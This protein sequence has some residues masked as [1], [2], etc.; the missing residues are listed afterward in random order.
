MRF[1]PC[2][3]IHNGRV[4]QIV[5]GTLNEKCAVENFVSDKDAS[6]YAEIYKENKLY[7]GHIIML[8]PGNETQALMALK[9]F[10]GGMQ[11]GGGINPTNAFKFLDAGASHVIVT[12]YIFKDGIF[13]IDNLKSIKEKVGRDKLV[14]DLSCR[15]KNNSY[16][17]V[18]E[19]WQNFTEFTISKENIK[20]LEDYCSE[21]LVHAVDVEGMKEGVDSELIG[22]LADSVSIPVTYA[23]GVKD[24]SDITEVYKAGN[25]RIDLTI[26]SALDIFG[27][28]MQ[29]NDVIN[30]NE[31]KTT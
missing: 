8:G 12:S 5:G 28:A 20:S 11:I 17:V 4:K 27:G 6:Y 7:G 23:G 21:F 29:F 30:R 19:R 31:F 14:I 2:I 1:R 15:K 26:G 10:P 9:V 25:G 18:T 3:D 24:Y 22:I 16:Y 13:S